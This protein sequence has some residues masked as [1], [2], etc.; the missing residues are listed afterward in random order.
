MRQL[1]GMD[2]SFLYLETPNAPGHVF[3]VWIYDQSSASGG[4]V[5]FTRVLEHVRD[6]LHVSRTFRQRLAQVPLGLDHPYW[7]E[8]PDFDLEFHVRHIA[9]PGPGDWRQFCIQVARSALS[10][11]R[12]QPTAMGDVRDRGTRQHRRPPQGQLRDRH[13]DPSCGDRR[14]DAAR[15]HQRAQ[16]DVGRCCQHRGHLG[17]ASGVR[18]D[19]VRAVV[20]G[21][22]Q[23]C[24]QADAARSPGRGGGAGGGGTTSRAASATQ[25]RASIAVC[26]AEN[27]FQ[28][29]RDDAPGGGGSQLRPRDRETDQGRCSR[30]DGERCR[31]HRRGRCPPR[32]PPGE[33]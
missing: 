12:P 19:G 18:A 16:R 2:A 25:L 29:S 14:C 11:A 22:V 4:K 21:G 24:E 28:R 17:V 13:Q 27:P 30:R 1:S 20:E 3:S 8:D 6:R 9:L 7:I 5:A 15:D 10:S 31:D 26:G 23:C 33:R 32:V